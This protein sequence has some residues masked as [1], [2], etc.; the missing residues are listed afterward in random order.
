M[1]Q[2]R[3]AE[4]GQ[5]TQTARHLLRETTASTP[6]MMLVSNDPTGRS[7]IKYTIV[8]NVGGQV[9]EI[10]AT[11]STE[12]MPETLLKVDYDIKPG[13]GIEVNFA[14][15]NGRAPNRR[16]RRRRS[17]SSPISWAGLNSRPPR[18]SASASAIERGCGMAPERPSCSHG[19]L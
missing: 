10:A 7:S 2:T 8:R 6:R 5:R 11:E 15:D 13:L 14:S 17:R 3:L 4:I 1:T 18:S 9:N 19:G 12:L 16:F